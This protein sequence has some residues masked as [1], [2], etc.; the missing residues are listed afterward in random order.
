MKKN[1]GFSIEI[2]DDLNA[3]IFNTKIEVFVTLKKDVF[4]LSVIERNWNT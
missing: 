3:E 4:T 1:N 2:N